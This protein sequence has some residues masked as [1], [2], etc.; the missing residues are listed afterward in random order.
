MN[1]QALFDCLADPTRRRVLALLAREGELCV[2]ELTEAL[3]LDQPKVSRHLGVI[4]EAGLV[5]ARREGTWMIYRLAEG[6]PSWTTALIATLT[7]GAVAE[8]SADRA[9]L[10]RM[11]F[12]PS[13]QLA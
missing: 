2:C 6:L 8:L 1:S 4:R 5:T 9:R 10:A 3:A 12:R 7:Q 13:H 11:S